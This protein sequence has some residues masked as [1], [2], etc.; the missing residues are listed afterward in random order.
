[1]KHY[2]NR[3]SI[4]L[5][6]ISL[7]AAASCSD[8]G[9]LSGGSGGGGEPLIAGPVD[10]EDPEIPK[11]ELPGGK[12]GNLHL[13]FY[14]E[15][16]MAYMSTSMGA[17]DPDPTGHSPSND[18]DGDGILNS[19]EIITNPFVADY[20]RIVTRIT[21]PIT[22][23][24]R[25]STSSVEENYTETLTESDLQETIKNSMEDKHYTSANQKTTPYVTKESVSEEGK[26]ADSYGYSGSESSK[27]AFN[28]NTEVE[29]GSKVG[30][31]AKLAYGF[32][33]QTERST[34]NSE[35]SSVED[36]FSSSNMSEKTVFKD[37]DYIDNQDRNGVEFTSDTVQRMTSNY[38]KSTK[39]K[40]TEKIGPEDG[41]VRASMFIK[42][43][44]VNMPVEMSNVKCTLSF[45]T[46]S[47]QHL[48]VKTFTLLNENGSQFNQEV[49]GDEE[50]GPYTIEFKNLNT[51]EV[52]VALAN[53]YVPQI[54]VVSYD[55]HRV[56]D[57]NYNPGVDNL[58]IV[59]ETAKARTA[60]IKIIGENIRDTYR[61]CAFDTENLDEVSGD[62]DISP[63]I[64]LKKA[65]FRILRDRVGNG[66]SWETDKGG[67]D[68][69]V[70]D[71]NL[72][73]KAVASNKEEYVFSESNYEGNTWNNFETYVKTYINER[74]ETK[75]IE[76]IR[77]IGKL[78]KYNPFNQEDNTAY[79]PNELLNKEEVLK[80]KF[81]VV[82]HNGRY[83]EGDLN[84]P[85]WAGE[86]YEIVCMDMYDF[87]QHMQSYAYAPFQTQSRMLFDTR[88]NALSDGAGDYS[89]AVYLG[90][91]LANDV[92]QLEIDLLQ[93]RFLFDPADQSKGF[94][95]AYEDKEEKKSYLYNFDY[96]FQKDEKITQGIPGEFT[97]SAYGGMNNIHVSI[98]ESENA[99]K[100][101]ITF[102]ETANSA[103]KG[104][105]TVTADELA[106][107]NGSAVLN[108]K[109]VI[110][111][112]SEITG[113]SGSGKEY[114]VSVSA[115]GTVYS[116]TVATKSSSKAIVVYVKEA[117]VSPTPFDFGSVGLTN[118][119]NVSINGSDDAEYYV[120]RCTGP[121]NYADGSPTVTEV[122]GHDGF[123]S[124]QVPSPAATKL[125]AQKFED[126]LYAIEVFARNNECTDYSVGAYSNTKHLL[127]KYDQY[128]N[129]K[130]FSP[131]IASQ[132]FG[133]EAV[134]FEVNFNE[135]SG[136]LKLQ[137]AD[138]T[139]NG[140]QHEDETKVIDCY[141]S[142][143]MDK[144]VQKFKIN[145]KPPTGNWGLPNVFAGGRDDTKV[146]IR[147]IPKPKYRDSIWMRPEM[148]GAGDPIR[149]YADYGSAPRY[150][151]FDFLYGNDKAVTD[152]TDYWAGLEE[153]DATLLEDTVASFHGD[154]IVSSEQVDD[155]FFSPMEQRIYLLRASV[156]NEVQVVE[157][158]RPNAPGYSTDPPFPED[159]TPG[160][161]HD[162]MYIKFENINSQY[163]QNY[164]IYLGDSSVDTED[165]IS[166]A[167]VDTTG[168]D[169]INAV[170]WLAVEPFGYSTQE[171][172][173]D[174]S[175][176]EYTDGNTY[177]VCV[178]A[179]NKYGVSIPSCRKV[180]I[181][182][183]PE[184][185]ATFGSSRFGQTKWRSL[186]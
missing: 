76:T 110:T 178:A 102:E 25:I 68:L 23:E 83:Y 123:N 38:R 29:G 167:E 176:Y 175:K 105:V 27:D 141:F 28:L 159:Y 160:V 118:T 89:R 179:S 165:L 88:W 15:L 131:R 50:L 22:M 136:W 134:D 77:R 24:I 114:K 125:E 45:R 163:A 164:T 162:N 183:R 81:W 113:G 35:N 62:Y 37:V 32:G 121:I 8:G 46:P 129:Q 133:L 112:V 91:V 31:Y 126:G 4:F 152:I 144:D 82:F 3:L 72:K 64:S 180:I 74:N 155:Y 30:G 87:N 58:K 111:G 185:I 148:D 12:D 36:S 130:R 95:D 47:G 182:L 137:P 177:T 40:Q 67:S 119:I 79:N 117:E 11:Q 154:G 97:H 42:N 93:S 170:E 1:M 44:S 153:T 171:Y 73:W 138:P 6:L 14:G 48:P 166:K 55:M 86:R 18:Y 69:T 157:G 33:V 174:S 61:V 139:T 59:E 78:K 57:S 124:I 52:M 96:Q 145:F 106:K 60:T 169:W 122:I 75:R 116:T 156:S 49:Y 147:T 103:N 146:Y 66:E 181:P 150:M 34:S 56:E 5:L 41:Y 173:I 99:A 80:M 135:G 85:I 7:L 158:Y 70:A 51:R 21:S 108:S 2:I 92:V 104:T 100:Y 10:P 168:N 39:V 151:M 54:H 84:D 9:G 101:E 132:L 94:G 120:I 143:Y 128:Y 17:V 186:H 184:D 98:N 140:L 161:Y 63:G 127:V 26:H 20:P 43:L 90:R 65:L 13:L 53:G 109:S 172:I 107:K 142:S 71:S 115:V 149:N 19:E 16:G